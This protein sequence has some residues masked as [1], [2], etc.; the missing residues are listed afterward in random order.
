MPTITPY[1]TDKFTAH[2]VES[3]PSPPDNG[4]L[5][6]VWLVDDFTKD[7]PVGDVKVKIKQLGKT[8]VKNLSGYYIFNG[9]P[10]GNHTVGVESALYF[11]GEKT[12]NPSTLDTKNPVIE[13]P[14]KPGPAYPFPDHATLVRGFVGASF[15]DAEVEVTVAATRPPIEFPKAK[16][17]AKGE[18]VLY[19]QGIK[20]ENIIIKI[21]KNGNTKIA[22]TTIKEG[23]TVS[24][25]SNSFHNQDW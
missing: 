7:Q 19:F 11:T 2:L 18:F 23:K 6:A 8:G 20:I 3:L 13:I 9:L 1:I 24:L 22:N 12:I 17:N 25:G 16:T 10:P 14:L 15:E 21:H 4:L 5:L